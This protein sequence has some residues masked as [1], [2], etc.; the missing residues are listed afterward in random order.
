ME[1]ASWRS[2]RLLLAVMSS[3]LA[4]TRA[5][6]PAPPPDYRPRNFAIL[7]IGHSGPFAML[8]RPSLREA[9]SLQSEFE[10]ELDADIDED[11]L[12]ATSQ[13]ASASFDILPSP[14]PGLTPNCSPLP[15]RTR[16]D[17]SAAESVLP[18]QHR[19]PVGG[20]DHKGE[21]PERSHRAKRSPQ[22]TPPP[23]ADA[24]FAR[25][26]GL[27]EG[28]PGVTT[29]RSPSRGACRRFA[30]H[31]EYKQFRACAPR[32]NGTSFDSSRSTRRVGVQPVVLRPRGHHMG[33]V[34]FT[35]GARPSLPAGEPEGVV[36]DLRLIEP[37]DVGRPHLGT[38][39]TLSPGE[40]ADRLADDAAR[41]AVQKQE[42]TPESMMRPSESP[43]R[44]DEA[45][46]IVGYQAASNRP[47]LA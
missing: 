7:K 8:T 28:C 34:S 15:S 5:S 44:R 22:W 6:H 12:T 38:P 37:R 40:V 4:L 32:T 29:C 21:M 30:G 19:P 47:A 17:R 36:E 11:E 43:Q 13:P 20:R 25:T 31:R 1:F 26:I 23:S 18:G 2:Q 14:R 41:A 9:D 16:R 39:P 10:D 24:P 45:H 3:P 33:D 42:D 27:A 46:G 35:N